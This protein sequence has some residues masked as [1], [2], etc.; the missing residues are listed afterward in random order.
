MLEFFDTKSL[1]FNRH[2]ENAVVCQELVALCTDLNHGL[3]YFL[4][5]EQRVETEVG[6]LLREIVLRNRDHAIV[7]YLSGRGFRWQVQVGLDHVLELI[8]WLFHGLVNDDPVHCA[9]VVKVN[10]LED[11]GCVNSAIFIIFAA[12]HFFLKEAG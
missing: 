9:A 6:K 7:W 12:L 3:D 11:G 10:L 2:I 8:G 4:L 5:D 1:P